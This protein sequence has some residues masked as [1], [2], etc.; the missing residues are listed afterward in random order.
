M[1]QVPQ[2]RLTLPAVA[3]RL[4]RGVRLH[5]AE[6]PFC[7]LKNC[8]DR[9]SAVLLGSGG[10]VAFEVGPPRLLCHLGTYGV[11]TLRAAWKV[12]ECQDLAECRAA[13]YGQN[14]EFSGAVA[15]SKKLV[16]VLLHLK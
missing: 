15:L 2:P 14:L 10:G 6:L 3:G 9:S 12:P 5:R 4:E 16:K 13:V 8:D 1:H 7:S 11:P